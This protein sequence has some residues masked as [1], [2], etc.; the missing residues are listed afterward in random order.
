MA[1]TDWDPVL[2]P[3]QA[4]VGGTEAHNGSKAYYFGEHT[5]HFTV[6]KGSQND[7]PT[8]A[9]VYQW[10]WHDSSYPRISF[11]FRVQDADN[12]YA[13]HHDA[14]SS[15]VAVFLSDAGTVSTESQKNTDVDPT[16]QGSWVNERATMWEDA[17][18][19]NFRLEY[20]DGTAWRNI[21]PDMTVGTPTIGTGGA[22]GIGSLVDISSNQLGTS[23]G[24]SE[25]HRDDVEVYY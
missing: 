9:R 16:F 10:I 22:V 12:W 19:L 25:E 8:E 21:C 17:G 20:Y 23:G 5:D 2:N 7:T 14:T 3:D 6:Y 24:T 1:T 13:V 18:D 4:G 15:Q 11:V